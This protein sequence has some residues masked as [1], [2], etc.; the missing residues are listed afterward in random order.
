MPSKD[1]KMRRILRKIFGDFL[2]QQSFIGRFPNY[3]RIEDNTLHLLSFQFDTYG[4]AF[5]LELATHPAES[6]QVSWRRPIPV[7]ELTAAHLPPET[8]VRLQAKANR[9]SLPEDWFRFDSF[10]DEYDF[11]QLAEHVKTLFPQVNDWLREKREG[12]N[13]LSPVAK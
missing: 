4:G 11:I 7:E 1:R 2:Q 5:F 8:R 6:L 13:I 3:R 9:H 10:T 12:I